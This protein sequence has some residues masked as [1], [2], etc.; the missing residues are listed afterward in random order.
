[1]LKLLLAALF[2]SAAAPALACDCNPNRDKY[3]TTLADSLA[4]LRA[5][6]VKRGKPAA[7]V[8]ALEAEVVEIKMTKV[9][10][11]DMPDGTKSPIERRD[12]RLLIQNPIYDPNAYL[13]VGAGGVI[14]VAGGSGASCDVVLHQFQPGRKYRLI[15]RK[16]YED[17]SLFSL[18]ACGVHWEA[19]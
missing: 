14:T 2:L 13:P 19:L 11:Y 10:E 3:M 16:K 8:A 15:L 5:E 17:P 1:M 6:A 9:G 12:M 18:P 4:F 7:D